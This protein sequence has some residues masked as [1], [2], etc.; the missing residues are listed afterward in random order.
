M[1]IKDTDDLLLTIVKLGGINIEDASGN[2]FEPAIDN[3]KSNSVGAYRLFKKDGMTFDELREALQE[4]GWY[5]QEDPNRPSVLGANEVMEDIREAVT[6]AQDNEFVY[7]GDKQA[8][9]EFLKRD[10]SFAEE[11]LSELEGIVSS[12]KSQLSPEEAGRTDFIGITDSDVLNSINYFDEVQGAFNEDRAYPQEGAETVG[13]DSQAID[14]G[15]VRGVEG[16]ATGV[17][18]IDEAVSEASSQARDG[19]TRPDIQDRGLDPGGE[20]LSAANQTEPSGSVSRSGPVFIPSPDADALKSRET[21]TT[22]SPDEFLNLV[23]DLPESRVQIDSEKFIR[24]QISKGEAL[25]TPYLLFDLDDNGVATVTGHEGRHRARVLKEMGITE[26]PVRLRSTGRN[27]IR[28]S[29]QADSKNRDR[30]DVPW[31]TTLKPQKG[32]SGTAVAFPI[33][34]PLAAATENNFALESYTEGDI[35]NLENRDIDALYRQ[36]QLDREGENYA[37]SGGDATVSTGSD[38]M[39]NTQGNDLFS[40]QPAQTDNSGRAKPG[41]EYGLNGEFYQGGQFMPASARTKKGEYKFEL[42]DKP[43]L[44]RELIAPGEFAV[45]PPGKR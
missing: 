6:L 40:Q 3:P 34:D 1:T 27:E 37:L 24:E 33:A 4:R 43:G 29:E 36:E 13:G 44:G 22:I 20:T 23:D 26:M 41:G 21:A 17:Q 19:A 28:W 42:S 8:E 11:S 18:R 2:G 32:S 15:G 16:G 12:Y 7:K 25:E 31:P 30:L 45:P 38:R 35:T 39:Q 14:A 9:I 5:S 10:I